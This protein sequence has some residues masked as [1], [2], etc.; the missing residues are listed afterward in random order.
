M[1]PFDELH[2]VVFD[3]ETRKSADEV[4]GWDNLRA[5]K[6]GCSILVAHDSATNDYHFFDDHTLN[7]FASMVEAPDVILVG[8]NSKWFDLLVVQGILGRRLQIKHHIDIFDSIKDALDREGRTRERGWKLGDTALRSM[9]M[10]KSGE[11]A[12]APELARAHRYAELITYCKNDV[13]LTRQLLDYIRRHGGVADR[14][15]ALL[16]LDVPEWL[17]LPAKAT[18]EA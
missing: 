8:Y 14:D 18:L 2:I 15:G 12:F 16:E 17:L 11:G 5:G 6:G 1:T 4:G 3:L 7:D 10:C 9:G 13:L